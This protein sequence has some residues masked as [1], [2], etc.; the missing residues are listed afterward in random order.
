ML[1]ISI[2][3]INIC[4]LI[5]YMKRNENP[6]EAEWNDS[7]SNAL[8]DSRVADVFSHAGW[9]VDRAPRAV[10]HRQPDMILAKGDHKYI[11]EIKEAP[12]GGARQL[13]ALWSMAWLQACQA[14]RA[15]DP[16]AFPLAIVVAPRISRRAADQL[17]AFAEE[18]ALGAAVGVMDGRGF[19]RFRGPGLDV[20]NA[21]ERQEI[22]GPQNQSEEGANL[23]SDKNQWMMKLLLAPRVPQ[24]LLGGPRGEYRNASELARA[25]D[26]SVMSAFRFV[27][28]LNHDGFLDESSAA[29]RLVRLDELF[30]RWRASVASSRIRERPMRFLLPSNPQK[31]IDRLRKHEPS[32][33][34]L[35]SAADALGFGHV[36]GVPPYIYVRE[37]ANSAS[38]GRNNLVPCARGEAPDII[39]RQPS[40]EESVFRAM[41]QR[42]G[43]ASCDIIQ[44]WLDVA[45]YPSRGREQAELIERRVIKQ[46]VNGS[47]A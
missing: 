23:F 36:H 7:Q 32:C 22:S 39:L 34:A 27:R 33:L 20:L 11:A 42:D 19:R 1:I 26:V 25:A 37:L 14:V 24:Q 38:A 8:A 12:A 41:V 6:P 4:V 21:D 30:E 5:Y 3:L 28:Q 9:S 43:P 35:F 13:I 31:E 29:L 2:A 45:A 46:I 17:F 44:V 16:H 40:A 10:N 47:D 18:N 15:I